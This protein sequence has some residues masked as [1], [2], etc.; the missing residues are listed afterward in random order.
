MPSTT[1]SQQLVAP[2]RPIPLQRPLST[3]TVGAAVAVAGAGDGSGAA[4]GRDTGAAEGADLTARTAGQGA[5][6]RAGT[7][8]FLETLMHG[9]L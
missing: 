1:C 8:H 3:V 5:R 6:L 9:A 2:H 4:C 7:M